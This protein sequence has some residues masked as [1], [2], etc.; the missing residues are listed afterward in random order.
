MLY[1][2]AVIS[3]QAANGRLSHFN[4]TTP[5]YTALF[6]FMGVAITVLTIWTGYMGYLFFRQNQFNVPMLYIWGIRI[7]IIIFVIFSFEGGIMAQRLAHTVG[8]AD[9]SAGLPLVNWS[10]RY[11]DLRIAH[12]FGM[13]ALQIIPL[14]SY[15]IAK[16]KTQVIVFSLGYVALVA[17]L[18]LR[19][20]AG[21]PL[22]A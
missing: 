11:G 10:K 8:G 12:F 6:A 15:F 1:E 13:H 19:A 22:F 2:V 17:A 7:G 9:G 18:L 16:T 3:W 4:H 21:M 20:M 14:F 5:L